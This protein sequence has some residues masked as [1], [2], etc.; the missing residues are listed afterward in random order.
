MDESWGIHLTRV[1]GD[2]PAQVDALADRFGGRVG[3]H[4]ILGRLDRRARRSR[5]GRALGRDGHARADAGRPGRARDHF[6]STSRGQLARGSLYVG[7]PGRFRENARAMPMGPEDLTY[8]GPTD[9]L[10][11][12]AEHPARRW[13]YSM[14]RSFFA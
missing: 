10:W 14:R 6:V 2:A 5:I 13:L 7:E 11:S 9:L 12:L 4:G 8:E 3:L 1:A